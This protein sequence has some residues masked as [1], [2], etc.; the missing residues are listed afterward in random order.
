LISAAFTAFAINSVQ[1]QDRKVIAT[2]NAPN[3]I[4]PYSA[5]RHSSG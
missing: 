4:G 2:P 5:S 3:A 1:A